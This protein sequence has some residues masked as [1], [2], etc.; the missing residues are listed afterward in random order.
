MTR[1]CWLCGDKLHWMVDYDPEGVLGIEGLEGQIT[2]LRC[3]G[4]KAEIEYRLI[5]KD[6]EPF[7]Q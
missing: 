2:F 6:G 3:T 4:C 5:L 1:G 7:N